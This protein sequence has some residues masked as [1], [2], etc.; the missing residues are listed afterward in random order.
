M[1]LRKI[2]FN[3]ELGV[4]ILL[5]VFNG[6]CFT[7][8]SPPIEY[9]I[10]PAREKVFPSKRIEYPHLKVRLLSLKLPGYL[11]RLQIVFFKEKDRLGI[12]EANLWAE[13]LRDSISR[14]FK[15]YMFDKE[16]VFVEVL[17]WNETLI[18]DYEINVE[19]SRLEVFSNGRGKIEA[20]WTL[21]KFRKSDPLRSGNDLFEFS[22]EGKA[23]QPIVDSIAHLL[24]KMWA[25][26]AQDLNNV[27]LSH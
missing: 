4:M 3:S 9:S 23:N 24:E 10:L 1:K 18:P 6:G 11:D 7:P 21:Y 22:G 13:P 8:S 17:P 19:I 25:R 2:L 16:N 27:N 26:I 15:E 12:L 5:V 14:D 20:Y